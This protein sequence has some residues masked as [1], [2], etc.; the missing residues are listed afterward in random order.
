MFCLR[1][2]NAAITGITSSGGRICTPY[3][4]NCIIPYG[5]Q[6][7]YLHTAQTAG[8]VFVRRAERG[9]YSMFLYAEGDKLLLQFF[10]MT[11]S[12]KR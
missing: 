3:R 4:E 6:G 11:K 5:P 9:A 12:D 10:C 1:K 8:A 7:Q 2:K